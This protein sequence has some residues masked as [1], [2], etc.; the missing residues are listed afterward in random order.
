[1]IMGNQI[2]VFHLLIV[3]TREKTATFFWNLRDFCYSVR[4][5]LLLIICNEVQQE[6]VERENEIIMPVKH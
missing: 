2:G 1:M 4:A 3:R 5:L 6:N